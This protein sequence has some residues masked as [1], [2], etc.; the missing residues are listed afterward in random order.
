VVLAVLG[1][2][3]PTASIAVSAALYPSFSLWSNAFS[4][5][6]KASSSSVAPVFNVGIALG[7]YLLA[8][9]AR[10][11]VDY[12]P[13][14]VVFYIMCFLLTCVAI[15]NEDYGAL[16]FYVSMAFF[17]ALATFVG[18][19][20]AKGRSLALASGLAISIALWMSH[21]MTSTPPGA[22]IPEA[23]SIAVG[24]AAIARRLLNTLRGLER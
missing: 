14:R 6:G 21:F 19:E 11:V 24:Y 2:A 16:H 22:A 23:T 3:I 10:A 1:M 12:A 18:I 13:Q 5:L 7:A 15:V 4:D 9:S 17:L 20:A 8:L